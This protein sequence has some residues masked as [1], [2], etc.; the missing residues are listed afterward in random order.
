MDP[1]EIYDLDSFQRN[2][3]RKD[4]EREIEAL[5]AELLGKILILNATREIEYPKKINGICHMSYLTNNLSQKRILLLGENHT[6]PKEPNVFTLLKFYIQ[7]TPV[8]LDIILEAQPI[9]KK[10]LFPNLINEIRYFFTNNEGESILPYSLHQF[11]IR[12]QLGLGNFF[13][14]TNHSEVEA[15]RKECKELFS[16]FDLKT[17][18]DFSPSE[19]LYAFLMKHWKTHPLILKER[20]N[21]KNMELEDRIFDLL[22]ERIN[23]V[24]RTAFDANWGKKGGEIEQTWYYLISVLSV[25]VDWLALLQLFNAGDNCIVYAGDAHTVLYRQFLI[26]EGFIDQYDVFLLHG[27]VDTCGVITLPDVPPLFE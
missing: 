12:P 6:K 17:S 19:K 3:I 27:R 8:F 20:E 2:E 10:S 13:I 23:Q 9:E 18:K 5:K 1:K 25:V 24:E 14:P 15:V 26:A 7:Q 16:N 4:V 22:N 21:L 11:D